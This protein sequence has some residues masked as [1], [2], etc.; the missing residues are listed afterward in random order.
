MC[1]KE[2]P[3]SRIG[4]LWLLAGMVFALS[5]CGH[6]GN[7]N[8]PVLSVPA[9]QTV[10]QGSALSFTASATDSDSDTVLFSLSGAPANATID[11]ATGA[12]S[13]VPTFDQI[14]SHHFTI[15]A[16][17]GKANA[18]RVI[19]ITVQ[20]D[21]ASDPQE[22]LAGGTLD[23]LAIPKYVTPLVIPPVMNTNGAADHYDIAVR[24]FKQQIL[25]GGLWNSVNGRADVF[26]ATTVWSY[27]PDADPAPDSSALGGGAGIA[28][29]PNSQLNYP[30]YTVE[31]L[32]DAPVAVKWVNDLVDANGNYL[33]H[34]L[35]I[36]QTVHW[37]NPPKA[38]GS[39]LLSTDCMGTSQQWYTGPVPIVPH[40]H[41][42]HVEGHSDGYPEAWWLPLAND[43]PAE[44]ATAGTLFDDSTGSNPGTRGYAQ[45]LYRN[46]QPAT[47][48][49]FHDHTLGM[50]RAN[51]YAGPAG[52]WLIRGT[53][54]GAAPVVDM[55]DDASTT[56]VNDGKLPGPAPVA[57]D[58]VLALN[59]PGE[60][61]RNAVR[62]IPIVIQD[63][64]FNADGSLFYPQDRAFFEG[65]DPDDLQID[66]APDSDVLPTWNPEAFFNV[67]VVNGVSW[68]KLD[69]A[70][71]Q[72]RF[73]LLNGC[74]SRFLNL[75]MFV[76]DPATGRIDPTQ[77]VPFYMIGADQ[78]YLPQV[79][80]DFHRLCHPP[81]G[82]RHSAGCRRRHRSGAGT[83][84]G[85]GRACRRPRRFLR[86][87]G[88]HRGAPDQYRPRCP[89]RRLQRRAG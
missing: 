67:M 16:T 52:F 2:F 20:I 29:A 32:A 51:V 76:V 34:L 39:G 17:D 57:G 18:S 8:A 10:V 15:T 42:A 82:R 1:C 12:F 77:E 26:P 80:K 74:N 54:Q 79:V 69:V 48:L 6:G 44:Y 19:Q 49:W 37:A 72:Y 86:P 62:E 46:D 71:A 5:A 78:G 70:Q 41:G 83:A 75:A 55:V 61:K 40:L 81:A 56:A 85:A 89:F 7:N 66:F 30:A 31:T 36:D 23:P 13:W 87:A 27:G 64:S 60:A 38:C 88:R 45:Y 43:I 11:T 24:Q 50:T 73:R 65:L 22:A 21:T 33:P 3:F 68:P 14:G 53:H 28:P 4:R 59:V 35:P 25:P 84:H 9:T 58:A 47:T 63:R